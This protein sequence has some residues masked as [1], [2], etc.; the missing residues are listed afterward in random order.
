MALKPEPRWSRANKASRPV[1]DT[2]TRT[3]TQDTSTTRVV[4]RAYSSWP[5][6]MLVVSTPR[7]DKAAHNLQPRGHHRDV[8]LQQLHAPSQEFLREE[9]TI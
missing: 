2:N 5:G 9:R 4:L 3:K 6:A 1:G 7:A 8:C